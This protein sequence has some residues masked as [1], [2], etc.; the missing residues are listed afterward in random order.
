MGWHSTYMLSKYLCFYI[1]GA[2][3]LRMLATFP[4]FPFSRTK[5]FFLLLFFFATLTSSYRYSSLSLVY[6]NGKRVSSSVSSVHQHSPPHSQQTILLIDGLPL[7]QNGYVQNAFVDTVVQFAQ[8]FG[9]S[10]NLTHKPKGIGLVII[11]PTVFSSADSN[12]IVTK[13]MKYPQYI[14][15]IKFHFPSLTR[16][17]ILFCFRNFFSLPCFLCN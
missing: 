6:S 12:I 10:F 9:S 17:I 11:I 13:L 15:H 3:F 14:Q 8:S 2:F 16:P 7:F 1:W 5:V 4:W